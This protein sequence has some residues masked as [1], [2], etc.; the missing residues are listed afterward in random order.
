MGGGVPYLPAAN[1]G[2][3]QRVMLVKAS[4]SFEIPDEPFQ[5][6]NWLPG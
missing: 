1:D 3:L 5:S 2:S 6:D 4:R